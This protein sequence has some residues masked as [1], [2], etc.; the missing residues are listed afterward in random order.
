MKYDGTFDDFVNDALRAA[1]DGLVTGGLSGMK[2]AIYNYINMAVLIGR[3][4]SQFKA[5]D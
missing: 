3:D 1:F 4:G 2:S 5:K